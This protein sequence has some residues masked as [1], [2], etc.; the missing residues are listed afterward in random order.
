MTTADALP[1]VEEEIE[2]YR[3]RLIYIE[4]YEGMVANLA[5]RMA[6][7][8][9]RQQERIALMCDMMAQGDWSASASDVAAKVR[10]GEF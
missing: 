9:S 3:Q 5:E 7:T 1:I 10:A 2:Q 6:E 8:M 4:V